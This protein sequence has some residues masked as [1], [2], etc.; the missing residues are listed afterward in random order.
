MIRVSVS[1]M[2]GDFSQ[3][4]ADKVHEAELLH[5]DVMDGEF[6]PKKTIGAE[7][8]ARIATPSIKEVHLMVQNPEE[9]IDDFADAGAE[10][11]SF[12]VE[13]TQSPAAVIGLIHN[14]GLQAGITLNPSTSIADIVDFIE[15]I[16]YVLIMSV[17]PGKGGQEFMP[18]ALEKIRRLRKHYPDLEIEVDGGINAI[19]GAECVNA[20]ANTLVAGTFIFLEKGREREKILELKKSNLELR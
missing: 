5:F 3:D 20:G 1:L 4:A 19:T 10:R 17:L 9:Y 12:H 16:D 13:A 11:I 2:A 18:E 15:E 7:D 6:V 8:V 14:R